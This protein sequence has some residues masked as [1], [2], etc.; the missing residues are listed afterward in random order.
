LAL[1]GLMRVY[2]NG[3]EFSLP[4][5]R[6]ERWNFYESFADPIKEFRHVCLDNEYPDDPNQSTPSVW[7]T[8]EEIWQTWQNFADMH[9]HPDK[10]RDNVFFPTLRETDLA[11]EEYHPTDDNGDQ[12][13]AFRHVTLTTEG[14]EY[15]PEMLLQRLG[16]TDD[17]TDSA[18]TADVDSDGG[19]DALDV[20]VGK[21]TQ[22][23][24]M[25]ST[26]VSTG[27]ILGQVD[28]RVD[29]VEELQGVLMRG[30]MEDRIEMTPDKE[31]RV[32]TQEVDN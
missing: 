16:V 13:R 18:G 10:N 5:T 23:A 11:L 27:T 20:V 6:E 14:W 29:S 25:R 17:D 2:Q 1:E 8:P 15:A 9:D 7:M 24:N 28:G 31:F 3:G 4:E 30:V 12:Y 32:A 19:R 22:I 26:T 21:L